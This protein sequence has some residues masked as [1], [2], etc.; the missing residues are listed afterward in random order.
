MEACIQGTS[1]IEFSFV[2]CLSCFIVRWI[3]TTRAPTE[4][5]NNDAELL[6]TTSGTIKN[7]FDC[8]QV[9]YANK[10]YVLY[11]LKG[12]INFNYELGGSYGSTHYISDRGESGTDSEWTN[13]CCDKI[14][15]FHFRIS[16][17][18]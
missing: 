4:R 11:I 2:S 1:Y 13:C 15:I 6:R 12:N 10:I 18:F 5:N 7:K 14:I 9:F 8:V 16:T 3:H 17:S